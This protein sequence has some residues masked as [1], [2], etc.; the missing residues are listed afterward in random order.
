MNLA[1]RTILT[2]QTFRLCDR[3][4]YKY[5]QIPIASKCPIIQRRNYCE[6]R[7]ESRRLPQ[8][9]E[10]PPVVWPSFFKFIK[11]WMFANFIIR[12]Y[13][14]SEFSLYDFVEASK[15]AVEVCSLLLRLC[16]YAKEN[17]Y[18]NFCL[19]STC[20][21]PTLIFGNILGRFR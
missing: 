17:N 9:M 14:E 6:D 12:P 11:N 20:F 16:M 7:T 10:F 3:I 1:V 5:L 4:S 8:L 15:H 21:I 2:N 19:F 13:F 18:S